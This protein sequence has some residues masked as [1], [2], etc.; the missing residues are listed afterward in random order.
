MSSTPSSRHTE[1]R[2]R[3]GRVALLVGLGVIGV[4][5]VVAVGI[6]L[7]V[8]PTGDDEP[9]DVEVAASVTESGED[10]ESGGATGEGTGGDAGSEAAD[11]EDGS[12]AAASEDGAGGDEDVDGTGS[13]DGASATGDEDTTGGDA[14]GENGAT[15]GEDTQDDLDL[16]DPETLPGTDLVDP[17]DAVRRAVFRGGQVVL[18]GRVPSQEVADE[19]AEKAGRVVGPENVVVGYEVDPDAP[20]P[21]SA[22]LFVADRVLFDSGSSVVRPEFVPLLDLGVDLLERVPGS[23]LTV[24]GHTDE[25]GPEDFNLTLSQQRVD[26][27]V[28]YLTDAGV[29]PTRITGVA[30][31]ETDPIPGAGLDANRRTEFVVNDLL[32]G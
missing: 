28:A 6:S 31:G 27:V 20:L 19:I 14:A 8:L 13:G 10:G 3:N 21:S 18:E 29:D 30:R 7:V 12:E 24:I 25:V 5:V 9:A 2:R 1:P 11:G 32:D 23:S 15:D 26:A 22:P 16:P 17:A 4:A